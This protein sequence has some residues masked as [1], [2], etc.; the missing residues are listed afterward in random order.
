MIEDV[1]VANPIRMRKA[2][3]FILI[4][5]FSLRGVDHASLLCSD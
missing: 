5:P 1:K 4:P 3:L 2:F